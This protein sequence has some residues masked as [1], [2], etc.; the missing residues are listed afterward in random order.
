[1]V[2]DGYDAIAARHL[3]WIGEIQGDPRLRC[4]DKLQRRLADGADVADLGCGAGVPCT[5]L[6]AA[7]HSVLGVD[8]SGEQIRLA[9]ER[10]PGA[11]YEQR[12]VAT[13]CL[14]A[15]GL[16]AVTAFYSLTHVPREQHAGLLTRISRWLRPGGFLLATLS[17]TGQSDVVQDDFLGVPM[18]FSGFDAETNRQLLHAAGFDLLVDEV[19]TMQEPDGPATFLWVLGQKRSG[20]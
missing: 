10:V 1:M 3:G 11:R 15:D 18:F 12:D 16:D 19:V 4:L 13:L 8:I 14:P 17:A 7:R 20:G 6:L 2:R 9:R 5:K